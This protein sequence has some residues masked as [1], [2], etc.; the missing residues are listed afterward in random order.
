MKGCFFVEANVSEFTKK[1]FN[2]FI[3]I[4]KTIFFLKKYKLKKY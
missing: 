4:I 3:E 2:K 1:H